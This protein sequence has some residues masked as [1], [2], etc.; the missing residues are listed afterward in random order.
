ME[1]TIRISLLD[2]LR[3]RETETAKHDYSGVVKES[4]GEWNGALLSSVMSVGSVCTRVM[5]LQVYGVELLSAIFR[6]I[7]TSVR[8]RLVERH[9]SEN[10]HK[11]MA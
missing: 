9:L 7:F 2:D 11:C 5:D 6:R 8:L 3:M 10:I 1:D 4:A